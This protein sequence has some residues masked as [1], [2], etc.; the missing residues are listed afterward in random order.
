MKKLADKIWFNGQLKNW[1]D[2]NVHV[3]THALHYGT[4]VFEGIRAY[5]TPNGPVGF[6]LRDHI[7][8]LEDSAKIY[9]IKLPYTVDELVAACKQT[10]IIQIPGELSACK[11]IDIGDGVLADE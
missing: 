9:G 8:R 10:F 11:A 7:R 2:A 3:L 6:R 5:D 4:S 1:E